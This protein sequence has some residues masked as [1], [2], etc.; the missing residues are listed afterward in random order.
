MQLRDI[1]IAITVFK[2]YIGPLATTR[3]FCLSCSTSCALV[4]AARVEQVGTKSWSSIIDLIKL[5]W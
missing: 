1:G 3:G 5:I 4:K 2:R